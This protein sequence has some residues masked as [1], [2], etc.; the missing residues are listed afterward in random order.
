MC[1]WKNWIWPGIITAALLTLLATFFTRP[2]VEDELTSKAMDALK[3]NHPWAAVALS[4]RDLTLTGTAP[5]EAAQMDALKAADAAYDVRVA[6]SNAGLLP[7]A[8]PYIFGAVKSDD[9][10]TLTGNVPSET[11]R[12]AIAAAAAKALPGVAVTDKMTL[13]AGM[14]E[15]FDALAAY[16]LGQLAAFKSGDV[17]IS[18]QDYTV[19]GVAIDAAAFDAAMTAKGANLPGNGKIAAYEITPPAA[20][21]DYVLTGVKE[22][23]AITVTGFAPS[24]EVKAAI[25]SA[26]AQA[27]PGAGIIDQMAIASGAP[28]GVD[29]AAAGTFTLSRLAGLDQGRADLTAADLK[30]TGTAADADAKAAAEAALGAQLP[31]GLK[32]VAA[33][34]APDKPA[35]PVPTPN[36]QSNA[37]ATTPAAVVPPGKIV[38][39]DLCTDLIRRATGVKYITFDTDKA[40]LKEGF[41]GAVDELLFVAQTCPGVSFAIEGHTDSDASDS[42]NVSLSQRRADAI[43]NYLIAR[44]VPDKRLQASGKGESEPIAE[45]ATADGKARNRRIEFRVIQ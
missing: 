29:W 25:L 33:I 7:K 36:P 9:G 32:V 2:G 13:A 11:V 42:Y 14:P 24:P 45:N 22:N 6:Y 18:N 19:K 15:G 35:E 27:N 8:D 4:G 10:V 37:A 34:T 3:A 12:A 28:E 26:A 31:Q 41:T 21:S 39:P 1:Y 17:A 40:D 20:S 23:G 38:L 16:G 43:R 5:D 44:G 30:V